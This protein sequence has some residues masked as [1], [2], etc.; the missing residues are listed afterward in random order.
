MYGND[1]SNPKI[2]EEETPTINLICLLQRAQGASDQ[3]QG[4]SHLVHCLRTVSTQHAT[5]TGAGSV[6]LT[7]EKRVDT[8]DFGCNNFN[9]ITTETFQYQV[10]KLV[11]KSIFVLG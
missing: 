10:C 2:E 1:P 11:C 4:V 6:S 9:G 7:P 8:R 3:G 5:R